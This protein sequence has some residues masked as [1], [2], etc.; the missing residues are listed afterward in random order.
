MKSNR[1]KE[2]GN[3]D[4]V[5]KR[6]K[7]PE[8]D[9][10]S[11]TGGRPSVYTAESHLCPAK[12]LSQISGKHHLDALQ[13]KVCGSG[14]RKGRRLSPVRPPEQYSVGEILRAVEESIEPV[15]CIENGTPICETADSCSTLPIWKGLSA[16]INNY[17]NSITLA[18]AVNYKDEGEDV[19]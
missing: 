16:L 4:C 17:L 13:E 14:K 11:G 3:Y 6:A 10:V 9:D 15:K 19:T 18:D 5:H 7:C 2:S 12:Y 1:A 8:A